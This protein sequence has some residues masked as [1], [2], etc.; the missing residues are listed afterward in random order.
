MVP[1][2]CSLDDLGLRM[3]RARFLAAAHDALIIEQD[4]RHLVIKVSDQVP[5]EVVEELIAVESECCP[6]FD[7]DWQPAARRLSIAVPDAGHEPALA[8]VASALGPA[9]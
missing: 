6:F 3:Q 8:A 1:A 5:D 4:R 7:F 2:L 9:A